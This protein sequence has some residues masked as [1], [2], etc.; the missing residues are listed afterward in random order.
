[1]IL[2]DYNMTLNFARDTNNYLTDPHKKAR[3]KINQWLYNGD[4]VD[5][6][7][8]LHPGKSFYT[9]TKCADILRKDGDLMLG[10]PP[11]ETECFGP[12][13]GCHD[14]GLGCD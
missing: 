11:W 12:F 13:C 10:T 7:D 6:F 5:V 4:F 3:I 8:E 9:Q 2:G 1:M 14:S